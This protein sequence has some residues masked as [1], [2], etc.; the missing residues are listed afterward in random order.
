MS[1]LLYYILFGV[2]IIYILVDVFR[3]WYMYNTLQKNKL[4]LEEMKE[5]HKRLYEL[6]ILLERVNEIQESIQ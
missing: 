6:Q 4:I 1:D 3:I 2:L 5:K